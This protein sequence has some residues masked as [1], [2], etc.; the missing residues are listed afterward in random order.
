MCCPADCCRRSETVLESFKT[1]F[2][3]CVMECASCSVVSRRAWRR[4]TVCSLE[5]ENGCR[6]AAAMSSGMEVAFACNADSTVGG[7][8]GKFSVMMIRL[9]VN[10]GGRVSGSRKS[11]RD[12]EVTRKCTSNHTTIIL[13]SSLPHP[14][15]ESRLK[16][17]RTCE[18]SSFCA[19]EVIKYHIQSGRGL[20]NFFSS[21]FLRPHLQPPRLFPDLPPLPQRLFSIFAHEGW[22][23]C[24][25]ELSL[26]QTHR[27]I[28]GLFA[29]IIPYIFDQARPGSV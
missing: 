3:C 23:S 11:E 29:S 12:A 19:E 10:D 2:E 9:W 8:S 17:P 20:E 28:T 7:T 26:S 14:Y 4:A 18:S 25:I 13:G 22:H 1:V 27:H 15:P 6:L 24:R 16:A 21:G 5:A